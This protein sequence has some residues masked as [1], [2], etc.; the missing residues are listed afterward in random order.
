MRINREGKITGI[1]P[2]LP[3]YRNWIREHDPCVY[4]GRQPF[5]ERHTLDHVVPRAIGGKDS[6]GNNL[7]VACELCNKNK[8]SK[9]LLRVLL[10]ARHKALDAFVRGCVCRYCQERRDKKYYQGLNRIRIHGARLHGF[11]DSAAD[12]SL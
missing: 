8:G 11:R 7:A 10:E 12:Q 5:V 3:N 4:C 9:S 6:S 2:I 1:R